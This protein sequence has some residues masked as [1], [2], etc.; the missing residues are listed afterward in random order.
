MSSPWCGH[1]DIR[2][3]AWDMYFWQLQTDKVLTSQFPTP[4]GSTGVNTTLDWGQTLAAEGRSP[5]AVYRIH[6]PDS[7]ANAILVE[8]AAQ[9]NKPT[10]NWEPTN[11]NETNC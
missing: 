10:W 11:S 7:S 6:L 5:D 4:S 8:A 2:K 1:P 3:P 9:R